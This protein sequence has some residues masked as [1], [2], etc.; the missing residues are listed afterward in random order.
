MKKRLVVSVLVLLAL[1]NV[2]ESVASD[3]F[4][5]SVGMLSWYNKY[6]PIS[7]IAGMDVPKSTYAFMNGPTVTAH[8]K[9]LSLGATY[10]ISSN[11]YELVAADTLV[12]A[13]RSTANSAASRTDIDVVTG[14][15]LRPQV[16]LTAGYKGIFVDDVITLVSQGVSANAKRNV[17]YNLGS[18][19]ATFTIP[20]GD[21][22]RW[23]FSGNALLGVYHNDVSYPANY[24]RLNEPD[25]NSTAWGGSADASLIYTIVGGL[26]AHLGVKGQYIKAGSDNS[27]FFGPTLN[28]DYRF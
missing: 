2:S 26:A 14:Y 4:S 21:D 9:N 19:G 22:F 12:T 15:L 3:N 18:L 11:K 16:T 23:V 24:R 8:Y 27:N 13:R 28:L 25:E 1:G 17:S 5:V 10:L 7:R 6:V 20:T